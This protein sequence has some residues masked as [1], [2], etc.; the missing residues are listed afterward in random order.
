MMQHEEA[1]K[2]NNVEA[3]PEPNPN[4]TIGILGTNNKPQESTPNVSEGPNHL[5]TNEEI[6]EREE[7]GD[8]LI[9][10]RNSIGSESYSKQNETGDHPQGTQKYLWISEIDDSQDGKSSLSYSQTNHELRGSSPPNASHEPD[11][12][13]ASHEPHEQKNHRESIEKENPEGKGPREQDNPQGKGPTEE[14][15]E[16]DALKKAASKKKLTF[17]EKKQK[18]KE[19]KIRKRLEKE[20]E[21]KKHWDEAKQA[22]ADKKVL[23][24]IIV[25]RNCEEHQWCTRHVAAK[26]EGNFSKCNLTFWFEH[27]TD[28]A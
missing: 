22:K 12:Q 17:D 20:L 1:P 14:Q 23:V 18:E 19:E 5:N 10:M 15:P 11:E 4:P 6:K 3:P 28:E 8:A 21:E 25:C 24:E 7:H 16:E 9:Y 26:Y 2:E 27:G 13:N